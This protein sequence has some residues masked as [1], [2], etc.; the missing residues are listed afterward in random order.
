MAP[1]PKSPRQPRKPS[2][3]GPR[4]G[5]PRK[6]PEEAEDQKRPS[7]PLPASLLDTTISD[8]EVYRPGTGAGADAGGAAGEG[9]ADGRGVDGG[10]ADASGRD[11]SAATPAMSITSKVGLEGLSR[12]KTLVLG[13]TALR[14]A[15][16]S[17]PSTSVL[18]TP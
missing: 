6:E 5:R 3:G 18:S 7:M 12:K 13:R 16:R 2:G 15:S 11:S 4:R 8:G 10:V 17:L 14:Q 9:T 1:N